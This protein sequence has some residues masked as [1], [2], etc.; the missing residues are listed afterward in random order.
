MPRPA[1]A[2]PREFP[3]TAVRNT[4]AVSRPGVIVK[5]LAAAMNA[6]NETEMEFIVCSPGRFQAFGLPIIA[7]S[8]ESKKFRSGR[9]I[10]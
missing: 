2:A 10:G 9:N 8:Q 4:S 3:V 6:A 7:G 5:T 1:S